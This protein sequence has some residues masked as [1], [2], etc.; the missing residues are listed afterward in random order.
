MNSS[1]TFSLQV[2]GLDAVDDAAPSRMDQILERLNKRNKERQNYIDVKLE[3]RHKDSAD[4]EGADYFS[5]AFAD[6][7]REIEIR[8]NFVSD[9]ASDKKLVG[10]GPPMD[11]AH[12]FAD[13]T[14]DI[15]ELQRYLTNSTMFLTDFKIKAC[16]S[17]IND[18][19][20]ICEETRVRLMPK[21]KFGFRQRKVTPQPALNPKLTKAGQ[22]PDAISSSSKLNYTLSNR[23]DA[24]ICLKGSEVN[25]VDV[26]I[27]ELRNCFVELQGAAGSVQISHCT[28]CTFLCGPIARSLFAEYCN[29]C[30]M[31]V[32]CQQMRL[33]SSSQCCINLHV[34]CRAI[35]EDCKG[36]EVAPYNYEY[37]GI[38][39]D[40]KITNLNKEQNNYADVAD[41]NWLSPDVPSPNW[42]LVKDC[43][44]TDWREK[45]EQFIKSYADNASL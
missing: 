9:A 39:E 2:E 40:F 45:K 7:V 3:Q 14:V 43:A 34:T 44:T 8:I 36:I 41:F 31:N 28:D 15:Q 21:K 10:D 22:K 25:G 13:I 17:I 42:H 27:A 4:S 32:A 19:T 1:K 30:S 12:H 29:N 20:Q 38:E 26:T 35:I 37:S 16:Q 23:T 33:H 18:L 6:K 11:L 5:Q 24:Y